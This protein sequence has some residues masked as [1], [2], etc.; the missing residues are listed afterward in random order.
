MNK[1]LI[2]IF[3]IIQFYSCKSLERIG[4]KDEKNSLSDV[5]E[6][7]ISG[8][9]S[10]NYLCERVDIQIGGD[11]AKN[12]HAKVFIT[13]GQSIFISLTYFLGIEV[14]RIQL[15][16]DSIKFINRISREYYFGEIENLLKL[17][18]INFEYEEIENFLL[19]GIPFNEKDNKKKTL[20]R[21]N[22]SG[23][24][25]I[26][27]YGVDSKRIVKAYFDKTTIREY[28]IELSDHVSKLYLVGSLSNYLT[29]PSYPGIID[30]SVLKGEKKTD[31]RIL[32]NKIENR[33]F[34]NTSFKIN[35]NYN[36]L[37]F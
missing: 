5:I 28:K 3:F 31:L 18:G 9:K 34:Q 11:E 2:Y 35:N 4:I 20:A 21:F 23:T 22:D 8:G 1:Y 19:K 17:S 32:I 7:K 16:R 27:T 36:E 6:K 12:F 37:V 30:V 15:S 29:E 33:V 25:Y 26:Y 24:D 13:E 10:V 14:G